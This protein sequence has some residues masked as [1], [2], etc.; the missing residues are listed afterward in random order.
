MP[1]R[2]LR[3]W[4][5]SEA[6]DKLSWQAEVLFT[7][8]IMKADDFGRFDGRPALLRSLLFPIKNGLRDTDITRW[9]AEC[10][11]ADLIR[12]YVA[13]GGKS[14]L[15]I[16]KFDQR[17]RVA[18]SKFP[19]PPKKNEAKFCKNDGHMSDICPQPAV[20]CPPESETE[21]ETDIE[22]TPPTPQCVGVGKKELWL[23]GQEPAAFRESFAQWLKHIEER[24]HKPVTEQ[25]RN[26]F[27][28]QCHAFG[29]ERSIKAIEFSIMQGWKTINEPRYQ[30][31]PIGSN[32]PEREF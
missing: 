21:T 16:V 26:A 13:D 3:D 8:L 31:N 4:T 20:I 7:R 19:E 10:E 28:K 29:N 15:E 22:T 5:D 32:E 1:N 18:K 9:L 17:L 25:Q 14:F 11:T 23:K 6:I 12:V 24:T 27:L 2:I 30:D